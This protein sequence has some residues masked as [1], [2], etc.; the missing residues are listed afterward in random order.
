MR[1]SPGTRVLTYAQRYDLPGSSISK[2]SPSRIVS[3]LTA[4]R[5]Q[6]LA[7][8]ARMSVSF[9]FYTMNVVRNK[10][11]NRFV[12]RRLGLKPERKTY[13]LISCITRRIS[14]VRNVDGIARDSRYRRGPREEVRGGRGRDVPHWE[15]R[16]TV[17]V[18]L[19]VDGDGSRLRERWMSSLCRGR[20]KTRCTA[21]RS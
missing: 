5:A 4:A 15:P 20:K 16:M 10:S 12:T 19:K 21:G 13:A 18:M 11:R 17:I 3:L 14:T 6:S 7:S 9:P 1:Y 8:G 2:R